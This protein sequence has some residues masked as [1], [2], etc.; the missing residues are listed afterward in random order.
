[1][2]KESNAV[3]AK[4]LAV[5]LIQSGKSGFGVVE[6]KDPAK[7]LAELYLS[8]LSRIE[9]ARDASGNK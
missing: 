8:I 1:M 4:D 6:A 3:I 9:S 5:A 7:F 2:S